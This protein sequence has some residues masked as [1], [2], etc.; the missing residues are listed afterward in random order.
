MTA[1]MSYP[2]NI[3]T[4]VSETRSSSP[5]PSRSSQTNIH[6]SPS[7]CYPSFPTSLSRVRGTFLSIRARQ[8]VYH[9][10]PR[11][12]GAEPPSVRV[13]VCIS[14]SPTRPEHIVCRKLSLSLPAYLCG[15]TVSFSD[16]ITSHGY[17]Q[18]HL[19]Q[20]YEDYIK[21]E[22]T[23]ENMVKKSYTEPKA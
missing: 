16:D 12:R 20:N 2:A 13:I 4:T 6:F 7:C 17:M 11:A 14:H 8:T 1:H 9:T 19:P 10:S 18:P 5:S 3:E 22:L 23:M 21:F 15:H